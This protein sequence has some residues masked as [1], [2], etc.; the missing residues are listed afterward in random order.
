MIIKNVLFEA[1]ST[2]F[3]CVWDNIKVCT[4]NFYNVIDKFIKKTTH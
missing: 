2:Y 1:T 4:T 3:D